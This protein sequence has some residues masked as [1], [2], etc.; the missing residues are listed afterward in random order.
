MYDENIVEML[1]E[2]L[3]SSSV[4]V[5]SARSDGS[6][7]KEDRLYR[8]VVWGYFFEQMGIAMVSP[9]EKPILSLACTQLYEDNFMCG[10]FARFCVAFFGAYQYSVLCTSQTQE[11]SPYISS[12]P[13][14]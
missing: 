7:G 5:A 13:E 12:I 6:S 11:N 9:R 14:F 1:F 10:H 2:M 4:E 8:F 3:F